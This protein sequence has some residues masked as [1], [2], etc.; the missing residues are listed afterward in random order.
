[1]KRILSTMALTALG[2][3]GVQ[4][5]HADGN[6]RFAEEGKVQIKIY[7]D[8]VFFG[9]QFSQYSSL[10]LDLTNI[11]KDIGR[12]SLGIAFSRDT[13]E[14]RGKSIYRRR[15]VLLTTPGRRSSTTS[16]SSCRRRP[17]S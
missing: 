3:L 16:R 12:H 6:A 13:T 8:D 7:F 11:L 10:E 9:N 4:P 17:E 1:M 14:R 5:A 2:A 15:P